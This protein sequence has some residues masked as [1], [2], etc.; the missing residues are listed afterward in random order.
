MTISEVE[1][2]VLTGQ[3]LIHRVDILQ[4]IGISLNPKIDVGQIEGAFIMGIG[5]WTMEELIYD[6]NTG[7]LGNYRTW[8]NVKKVI[9]FIHLKICF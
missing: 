5:F 8:V 7:S 9:N 4:D 6:P 3:H 2:D 1:V